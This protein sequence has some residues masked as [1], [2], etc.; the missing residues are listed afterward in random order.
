MPLREGEAGE[1]EMVK[2]D[3]EPGHGLHGIRFGGETERP[4][5]VRRLLSDA[6]SIEAAGETGRLE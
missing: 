3:T 5:D 4:F 6:G 2:F 1:I